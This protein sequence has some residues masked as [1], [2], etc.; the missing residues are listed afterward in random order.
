MYFFIEV[1]WMYSAVSISAAQQSDSI[2]HICIHAL[3]FYILF[4]YGISQNSEYSSLGYPVGPGCLSILYELYLMA[5]GTLFRERAEL[6]LK[7]G[8]IVPP[9][10]PGAKAQ[11]L[12]PHLQSW[13]TSIPADFPGTSMRPYRLYTGS[14]RH[15]DLM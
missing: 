6:I 3:F 9:H 12:F 4:H 14:D 7:A 15:P 11:L 13:K 5:L 10:R 2:I 1:L 8:R